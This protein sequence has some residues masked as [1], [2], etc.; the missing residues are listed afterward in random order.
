MKK[1][2]HEMIYEYM[3]YMILTKKIHTL[4]NNYCQ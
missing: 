1:E 3:K 2:I 4:G